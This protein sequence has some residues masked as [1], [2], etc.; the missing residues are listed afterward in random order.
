M[1][2]GRLNEASKVLAEIRNHHPN[3]VRIEEI[4]GDIALKGNQFAEATDAYRRYW[5]RSKNDIV[6]LK[7][8]HAMEEAETPVEEI[9]PL[10]DEW[11]NAIPQ[12][13]EA[14]LY[15]ARLLEG[16]DLA[17]A[18]L[19]EDYLVRWPDTPAILNNLSMRYIQL[20]R[21]SDA[22][23]PAETALS[24]APQNPAIMDTLGWALHLV[25]DSDRS[26]QL[27]ADALALDPENVEIQKHLETARGEI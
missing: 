1:D 8:L 7:L 27:L 19:Y 25:G 13:Q 4:T 26:V 14:L 22:V 10:V 16:D 21:V 23:G 6:A 11:R 18:A 20:G 24:L 5:E 12:S 9:Q 15:Q 3:S 17:I 2:A